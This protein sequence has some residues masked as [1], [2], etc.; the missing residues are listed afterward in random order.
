MNPASTY[1]HAMRKYPLAA[2][3]YL[4]GNKK[5]LLQL[6]KVSFSNRQGLPIIR[7]VRL[8]EERLRLCVPRCRRLPLVNLQQT[9]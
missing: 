4:L 7:L 6:P 2:L 5:D 1:N 9:C 3:S 8:H